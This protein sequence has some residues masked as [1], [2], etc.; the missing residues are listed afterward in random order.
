M[1]SPSSSKR[2]FG[3]ESDDAPD[4]TPQLPITSEL[5]AERLP[6]VSIPSQVSPMR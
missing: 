1:E 5:D 2:R 6:S 3:E 4:T